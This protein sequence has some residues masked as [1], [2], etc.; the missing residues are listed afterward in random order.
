MC[1]RSSANASQDSAA[2]ARTVKVSPSGTSMSL[3]SGAECETFRRL[4]ELLSQR[5]CL[6][7]ESGWICGMRVQGELQWREVRRRVDVMGLCS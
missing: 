5:W 6:Q 2:T 4:Y 7:E 3:R 1:R